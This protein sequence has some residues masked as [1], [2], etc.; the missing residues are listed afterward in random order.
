MHS[1]KTIEDVLNEDIQF[2][3]KAKALWK[4]MKTNVK[5]EAACILACE[6]GEWGTEI[7]AYGIGLPFMNEI[8]I[9]GGVALGGG[10][11]LYHV[12]QHAKAHNEGVPS[13]L[14]AAAY[15]G[16][17]E[18]GCI[19]GATL[20]EYS[21][22]KFVATVNN[23]LALSNI[24]V[25][26]AALIP[27]FGIG[28]TLMSSFTYTK[29]KE[30]VRWVSEKDAIKNIKAEGNLEHKL[31]KNKLEIKGQNSNMIIKEKGLPRTYHND[32]DKDKNSLYLIQ[33]K[34]ARAKPD[35][36]Q[37]VQDHAEHLF[38]EAGYS[39]NPVFNIYSCSTSCGEQEHEHDSCDHDH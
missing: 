29:K 38:E 39:I 20:A 6:F 14:D 12:Y 35:Y 17:T 28:L 11:A 33:S 16:S 21:A 27:A 2:G 8:G 18:S 25:R 7:L 22:G 23:P 36:G 24:L 26:G 37:I 13:L 34:I 15:A 19:I 10:Y 30:V 5:L 9:L 4:E 1:H 32:Y 3:D 31:N